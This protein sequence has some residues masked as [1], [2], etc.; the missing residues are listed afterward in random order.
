LQCSGW[1]HKLQLG[2]K[3]EA[4][5]KKEALDN[6]TAALGGLAHGLIINL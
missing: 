5:T 2:K 4:H 6:D 1:N 3:G